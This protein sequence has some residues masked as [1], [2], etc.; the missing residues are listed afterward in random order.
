MISIATPP[1]WSTLRLADDLDQQ[2]SALVTH[3]DA[4]IRAE[5]TGEWRRLARVAGAA[6][7]VLIGFGT[8]V[9]PVAGQLVSASL[10]LAPQRWY[11]PDPDDELEP[12]PVQPLT[13]PSGPAVRR[14]RLVRVPGPFGPMAELVVDYTVQVPRGEPWSVVLRTPALRH[15][16]QLVT[17]FDAVAGSLRVTAAVPDDAEPAFG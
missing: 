5:L 14:L 6:G 10:L 9:D 12:G 1:G 2:V 17:V 4:G 3:L 15:M 11:R 16:E 13:L 7:A 8:A